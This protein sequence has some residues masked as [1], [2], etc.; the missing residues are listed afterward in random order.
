MVSSQPI[1]N[2]IYQFFNHFKDYFEK[3]KWCSTALLLYSNAPAYCHV[4]NRLCTTVLI[5]SVFHTSCN[6]HLRYPKYFVF[7]YCGGSS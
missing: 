5:L 7:S 4:M 2:H 6:Y 3:V 1:P